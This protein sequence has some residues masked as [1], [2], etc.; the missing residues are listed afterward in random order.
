MFC[1]TVDSRDVYGMRFLLFFSF[2]GQVRGTV[3]T[4]TLDLMEPLQQKQWDRLCAFVRRIRKDKLVPY[5]VLM[6]M[7]T[8][9]RSPQRSL[10]RPGRAKPDP[11]PPPLPRY[12]PPRVLLLDVHRAH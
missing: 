11:D 4:I 12:I 10:A 9:R 3:T 6:A 5:K 8:V 2:H 1:C 7:L